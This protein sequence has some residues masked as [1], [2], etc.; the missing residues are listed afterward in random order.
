MTSAFS[1]PHNRTMTLILLA[2][3]GLLAIV[4]FKIGIADN[5]PGILLAF[6]AATAFVLAFVHPWRTEKKFKF[7]LLASLLG[8]VLFVILD[9]I[10]DAVVHNPANFGA[11]RHLMQSS[12]VDALSQIIIMLCPAAFIVGVVGSIAMFIRSR[13][14]PK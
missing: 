13:R 11:L 2:V 10:V 5:L 7:L 1:T 8:F 14:Q 12:A 3:C 9:I 4:A 6:L